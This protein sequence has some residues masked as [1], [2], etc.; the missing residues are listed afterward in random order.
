MQRASTLGARCPTLYAPG[1]SKRSPEQQL[2]DLLRGKTGIEELR[3][4]D[5]AVLAPGDPGHFPV[6]HPT[7]L[8]HSNS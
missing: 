1:N 5:N 4:R 8:L 7:L 3:P 6:N 2:P